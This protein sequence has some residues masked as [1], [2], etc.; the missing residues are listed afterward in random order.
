MSRYAPQVFLVRPREEAGWSAGG[1]GPKGG[2]GGGHFKNRYLYSK[3]ILVARRAR[4]S[5]VYHPANK[6]GCFVIPSARLPPYPH[7]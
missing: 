7:K 1:L 4:R 6:G 3:V 2:V 5:A